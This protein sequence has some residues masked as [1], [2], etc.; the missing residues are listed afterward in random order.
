M[1]NLSEREKLIK[2]CFDLVTST[3]PEDTYYFADDYTKIAEKF[4]DFILSRNPPALESKRESI[5]EKQEKVVDYMIKREDETGLDSYKIEQYL[6]DAEFIAKFSNPSSD[7]GGQ[8]FIDRAVEI[9]E[10]FDKNG[11]NANITGM[12]R[13]AL[14]AFKSGKGVK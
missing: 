9:C 8:E 12:A 10:Y 6:A 13:Q 3:I 7:V 14:T 5:A 2:E 1:K 4:A 11:W